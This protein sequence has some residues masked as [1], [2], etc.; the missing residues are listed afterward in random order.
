MAINPF[1]SRVFGRY[2]DS[3]YP[4]T[5]IWVRLWSSFIQG[6]AQVFYDDH[7]RTKNWW[8]KTKHLFSKV[9]SMGWE[10]C[11][12]TI[13]ETWK[14]KSRFSTIIKFWGSTEINTNACSS[15]ERIGSTFLCVYVHRLATIVCSCKCANDKWSTKELALTEIFLFHAHFGGR[16]LT[17]TDSSW[18]RNDSLLCEKCSDAVVIVSMCM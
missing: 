11:F 5:M 16:R 17:K 10:Y 8:K 2:T 18:P 3:I 1:C 12:M 6:N 4:Q 14:K 7:I 13:T 9:V 15:V